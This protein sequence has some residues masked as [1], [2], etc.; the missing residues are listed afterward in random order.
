MQ[1]MVYMKLQ[2]LFHNI[3]A[4]NWQMNINISE[5]DGL[6]LE[7]IQYT[8]SPLKSMAISCCAIMDLS[9]FYHT[10]PPGSYYSKLFTAS[11]CTISCEKSTNITSISGLILKI[12]RYL[13]RFV[14]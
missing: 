3:Q 8:H 11:F 4:K 12:I 2:I 9:V 1:Y 14:S 7:K 6:K 13:D 10:S 5:A